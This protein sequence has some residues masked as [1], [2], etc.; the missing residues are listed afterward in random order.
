[1]VFVVLGPPTYG[2]RRPIRTGEDTSEAAGMST[3]SSG[4]ASPM[5]QA[6]A[7]AASPSGR[8]T[9]SA[10]AA[11]V[12]RMTGPGTQAAESN[13]NYQEVWHYRKELLPKNIGY[14]QVDVTFVTKQGY[15][16]DVLQRDDPTL[17][18]LAAAKRSGPS[19]TD[20]SR[21]FHDATVCG[22]LDADPDGGGGGRRRRRRSPS[23]STKMKEQV[24]AEKWTDALATIEVIDVEAAKPANASVRRSSRGRW[25]STVASA[26]RTWAT[27]PR[28]RRTS[29]RS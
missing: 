3:V 9:S 1:M 19:R 18:T 25:R 15:G 11:L 2:G 23:S 26:R 24:K 13:N 5:A 7:Q 28:R 12:D 17:M 27:R 14:L 22:V 10:N 8:T 16:V 6:G 21:R 20:D 29:R 4:T